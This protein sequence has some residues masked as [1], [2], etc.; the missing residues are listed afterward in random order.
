MKIIEEDKKK[1]IYLDNEEELEI[2]TLFNSKI[3]LHI[4]CKNHT[5]Y[6]E[7]IV[8]KRIQQLRLEQEQ[9]SNLDDYLKNEK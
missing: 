7:D 6:V 9:I 1:I 8:E 4:S 3:I 5:L 2:K